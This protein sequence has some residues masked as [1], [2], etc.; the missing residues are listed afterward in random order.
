MPCVAQGKLRLILASILLV[1]DSKFLRVANER[2]LTRAGYTVLSSSDGEEA[3]RVAGEKLPDLIILDM[4]L[5]KLSGQQVLQALKNSSATAHIPVIV[6]SSLSQANEEKLRQDGAAAYL[7]KSRLL[8]GNNADF[9][10]QAIKRVL[11]QP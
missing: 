1:E 4:M 2:A 7:E 9:L 3:L 11:T 5:P 8:T 6:L 10:V